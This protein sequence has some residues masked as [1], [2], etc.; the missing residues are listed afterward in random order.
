MEIRR[1]PGTSM[2]STHD[3]SPVELLILGIDEPVE[4]HVD[5]GGPALPGEVPAAA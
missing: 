4:V 1:Y 2:G 3:P 5:P